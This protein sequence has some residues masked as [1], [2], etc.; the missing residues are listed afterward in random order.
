MSNSTRQQRILRLLQDDNR[1]RVIELGQHLGVSEATVRRDLDCL[2]EQGKLK[3][4][5]GGAVL[6]EQAAPELP[7]VHRMEENADEKRRIGQAAAA[8]IH[9]GDTVFIGSGTTTLEVAKHLRGRERITVITNALTV[10]NALAW[11]TDITLLG[12]GGILRLSEQSFVGHITALALKELRPQ[13]VIM[14]IRAISLSAGLTSDYVPEVS[15]D[16]V[17]ISCAPEVILVADHSKFDR[18]STALVAP[19]TAV[20]K[21]VTDNRVS[22]ETVGALESLG[23][24]VIVV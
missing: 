13:K 10:M 19:V 2:Q 22:S 21:I 24:E 7:V 4:V 8:L 9:E 14:G 15:T 17:I 20:H 11:K 16:R 3:R 12:T 6:V 23:I 1:V 18:V 5:H